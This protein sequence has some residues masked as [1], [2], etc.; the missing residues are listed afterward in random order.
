MK[1]IKIW[2]RDQVIE[3]KV[4][5]IRNYEEKTCK[6]WFIKKK[7]F[8]LNVCTIL[9]SRLFYVLLSLTSKLFLDNC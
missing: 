6:M 2:L 5:G 8:V 1:Y 4:I 7:N 9:A 3:R